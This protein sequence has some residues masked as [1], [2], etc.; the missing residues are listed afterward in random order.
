MRSMRVPNSSSGMRGAGTNSKSGSNPS[1]NFSSLVM[2]VTEGLSMRLWSFAGAMTTIRWP[3]HRR[4]RFG[5]SEHGVYWTCY[6]H[7]VEEPKTA[8][9]S[10][11]E[12][13]ACDALGHYVYRPRRDDRDDRCRGG[14]DV[15]RFLVCGGP[16]SRR[17]KQRV[18]GVDRVNHWR[19]PK[20]I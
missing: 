17:A 7:P 16:R 9:S 10:W 5:L 13:S 8:R 20:R 15:L 19:G 2:F 18:F 4:E 14:D 11:R 6:S 1:I 12:G 3:P